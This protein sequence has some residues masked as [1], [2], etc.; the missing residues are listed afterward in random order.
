MG[1]AHVLEAIRHTSE[2]RAAV[3]V[4]TDKC[5]ENREW[6]RAYREGDRLGGHDPYSASKASAELVTASYRAAFLHEPGAP[7][8]ATARGGNVIGGGDWS[9][10][11]LVPDLIRS[12]LADE[13]LIVR[14]PR[15]TRP[16]QH[17]LD[18][19][20]GYLLVGQRL[21]ADGTDIAEAWNF[22]PDQGGNQT[23]EQ[24]L[25]DLAREWPRLNW[26]VAS[27]PQPHEAA[28]LQLDSSKART[29]LGWRPVWNHETAIQ[30]TAGWY[31]RWLEHGEVVS[32][33]D[34]AAYSDDAVAAGLTW[35]QP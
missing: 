3:V 9:E 6:S 12:I 30:R 27:K 8:L 13:T 2:V 18:C 29:R 10:D 17:V 14:S 19:L 16:W 26:Q 22:G 25:Q 20:S 11:R 34:L 1:T 7:L 31:R 33:N 35:A 32:V 21:L 4:T 15:S 28:L 23:V 5:Y 24:V